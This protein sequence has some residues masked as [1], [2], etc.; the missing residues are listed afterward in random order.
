MTEH[1]KLAAF[2]PANR[3]F[4]DGLSMP[5]PE[6]QGITSGGVFVHL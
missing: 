6:G 3:L 2:V 4:E 5:L 1:N